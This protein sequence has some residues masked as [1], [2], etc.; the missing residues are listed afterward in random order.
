MII[1][2]KQIDLFGKMFLETAVIE[3]PFT[4]PNPMPNEACFITILEGQG[5][6]LSEVEELTVHTSEALLMKCGSYLSR[7]ISG[8][9]TKRYHAVAIH[10]HPDVIKKA[11]ASTL[12][13]FMNHS[14][15]MAYTS[16]MAK[17][18][19]S[20]L[21]QKYIEII[22]IYF[23]RPEIVTEELLVLKLKEI[24][25]LL[26]HTSDSQNVLEIFYNLF[27]PVEF[28]LKEI[29]EAHL[30]SDIS[31]AEL[32]QLSYMSLSTFKREFKK[33]FQAT[34]AQYIRQK[35]L[36]RAKELITVSSQSLT[37]IALSCGFRDSSQFSRLFK[38]M[39]GITP[40]NY[41]LLQREPN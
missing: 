4:K 20:D 25:L 14:G 30:F 16:S 19:M 9:S 33:V 1:E 28:K 27:S 22:Q 15:Q 21:L 6:W 34:P 40:S 39:Y 12:P 32:A 3:P 29:V 37:D 36:E 41:R 18:E 17:V 11:Y 2:H 5:Y 31:V 10:F 13:D 23:E 7:M 24:I 8:T 35:K 26:M 38:E